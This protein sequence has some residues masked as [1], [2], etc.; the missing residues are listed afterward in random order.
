MEA[1]GINKISLG[2]CRPKLYSRNSLFVRIKLAAA[3]VGSFETRLDA[4]NKYMIMDVA[5]F[6]N[7]RSVR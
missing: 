5:G 4:G 7:G 1:E 2:I 3:D 6:H